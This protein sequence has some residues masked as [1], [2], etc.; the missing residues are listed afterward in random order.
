MMALN[1]DFFF[2]SPK[3]ILY[4]IR[5]YCLSKPVHQFK[6]L[7]MQYDE[8]SDGTLDVQEIHH[9]ICRMGF[10]VEL[11]VAT[12]IMHMIDLDGDSKLDF[13][14]FRCAIL[15]ER[16]AKDFEEHANRMHNECKLQEEYRERCL[17]EPYRTSIMGP[18]AEPL[19]SSG[20]KYHKD[21]LD[22]QLAG[23]EP[24]LTA[25]EKTMRDIQAKRDSLKLEMSE[26]RKK[27]A[28]RHGERVRE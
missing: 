2:N 25:K 16:I 6:D 21:I 1:K 11:D 12:E 19:P 3:Y 4:A 17:M 23:L 28:Q 15:D 26:K 14:E 9:G 20:Y 5:T 7:F 18:A 13:A 22:K 10:N 24:K 27:D 8:N